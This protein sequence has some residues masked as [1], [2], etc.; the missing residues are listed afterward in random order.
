MDP[1]VIE[2][3]GITASALVLISFL[4]KG[5]R[6]IRLVNIVG[7]IIFIAYGIMLKSV[8]VTVMN[9]GLVIVHI[10]YLTKKKK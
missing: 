4:M 7:A 2:L 1:V 6:K 10:Y 9:V 3:I 8:S 5:E